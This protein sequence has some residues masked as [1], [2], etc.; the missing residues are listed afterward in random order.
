MYLGEPVVMTASSAASTMLRRRISAGRRER[1]EELSGGHVETLDAIGLGI[2]WVPD[3]NE[4]SDPNS[5]P[6]TDHHNSDDGPTPTKYAVR[7]TKKF[8]V[9]TMTTTAPALNAAPIGS[10]TASHRT[11]DVARGSPKL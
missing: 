10:S 8:V 7:D 11:V 3:R 9:R 5:Q 1:F 2:A 6:D 4:P